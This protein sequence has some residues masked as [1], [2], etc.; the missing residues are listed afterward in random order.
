[1]KKILLR[2]SIPIVLVGLAAVPAVTATTSH[3]QAGGLCYSCS[4]TNVIAPPPIV[5]PKI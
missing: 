3:S 5:L 2:L 4:Q 1:M